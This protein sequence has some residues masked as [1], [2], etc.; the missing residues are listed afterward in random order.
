MRCGTTSGLD[1]DL[2]ARATSMAN[3]AQ[4]LHREAIPSIRARFADAR[5]RFLRWNAT[6][7]VDEIC[8][9]VLTLADKVQVEAFLFPVPA[10]APSGRQPLAPV[11]ITLK[12]CRRHCCASA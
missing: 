4:I 1:P 9:K 10:T 2:H 7:L 6:F 12:P 11:M 8:E 5:S 3:A